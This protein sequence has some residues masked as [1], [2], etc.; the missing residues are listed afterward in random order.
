MAA[1]TR[2]IGG[3]DFHQWY[4]HVGGHKFK[5]A[6]IWSYSEKQLLECEL[7]ISFAPYDRV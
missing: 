7:D 6:G 5:Y 3:K 2:Y 4:E 1:P